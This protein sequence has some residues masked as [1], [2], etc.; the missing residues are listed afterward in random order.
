[1]LLG[2]RQFFERRG[3]PTP[4]VPTARDYVQNGL[5][6]MWDGIENVGYGQHDDNATSWIDLTG[7]G[8][9]WILKDS[10]TT[11]VFEVGA[12]YVKI[13]NVVSYSG[14]GHCTPSWSSGNDI[15]TI[16]I[17]LDNT[18]FDIISDTTARLVSF[19]VGNGAFDQTIHVK[20][21]LLAPNIFNKY[22]QVSLATG[23][24]AVS[25]VIGSQPVLLNGL[26]VQSVN[27]TFSGYTY[28]APVLGAYAATA[29]VGVKVKS[30]RIYGR[31][32]TDAERLA[33]Y[34]IDKARLN[35]P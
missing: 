3:S 21:T 16:E 18:D 5:I 7:G 24:N 22:G 2:A 15:I 29:A 1:M 19:G 13:L 8:A 26:F 23:T 9:N 35:V 28:S 10:N 27:R 6:A 25:L 31:S 32:L 30:M 33:N 20:G 4:S 14:I 12:D 17:V 34:S 11:E